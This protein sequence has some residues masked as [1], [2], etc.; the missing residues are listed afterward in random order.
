MSQIVDNHEI[1]KDAETQLQ[2]QDLGKSNPESS[3]R[4][5]ASARANG[6]KSN[7]AITPDGKAICAAT[8]GNFR[9]GMLAQTVVLASESRPRFEAM[10]DEYYAEYKPINQTERDLV[11]E[12]AIARWRLLRVLCVQKND[13]DL[14]IA[15]H[16]SAATTRHSPAVAATLAYRSLSDKGNSLSNAT[17]HE[18][19]FERQFHRALRQLQHLIDARLTGVVDTTPTLGPV[20]VFADS[21]G[22]FDNQEEN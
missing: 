8:S 22:T 13:F 14:E 19:A 16:Q 15:R 20:Q 3:P 11:E 4:K 7:G 6:A 2:P 10:L 12:M 9:H 18:S 1:S 21:S 17:R 5:L